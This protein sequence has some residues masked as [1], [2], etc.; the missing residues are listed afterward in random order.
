MSYFIIGLLEMNEETRSQQ[1]ANYAKDIVG[2]ALSFGYSMQFAHQFQDRFYRYVL[3][4]VRELYKKDLVKTI[5]FQLSDSP[6]T[7]TIDYGLT[8]FFQEISVHQHATVTQITLFKFLSSLWEKQY[9]KSAVFIFSYGLNSFK[10]LSCKE[11]SFNEMF[12]DISHEYME[13]TGDLNSCYFL[14]K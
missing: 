8:N 10:S 9:I 1:A 3:D 5:E 14:N 7:G 6:L 12:Y 2:L 4:P 13:G 11:I